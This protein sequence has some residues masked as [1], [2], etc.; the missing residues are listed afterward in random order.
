MSC[1]SDSGDSSCS[2]P[3]SECGND[4][5]SFT[6]AAT[7]SIHRLLLSYAAKVSE[8][9]ISSL[10]AELECPSQSLDSLRHTAMELRL[11]AKHNPD[12]RVRIAVVGG[13][14]SLVRLLSHADPLLQEHGVTTLLNLSICDDNKATIVEAGAIRPLVHALKS[15]ASPTARENA[16]CALLWL[17]QLDG[18]S[19]VALA[20]SRC[21]SPCSRPGARGARR[22][23]P[24]RY[25]RFAAARARTGST[26]WRPVPCGPCWT[27]WPT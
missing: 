2:E 24:R 17:S 7:A 11:L 25:T 20:P 9:A 8:D 19:A 13:V 15:A 26:A 6:P 27:S 12:N 16:V 5:L 4:N 10:V 22:T 14:R 1:Y 21:W 18:A 23:L 3:F